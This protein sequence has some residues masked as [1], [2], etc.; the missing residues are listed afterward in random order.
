MTTVLPRPR[1]AAAPRAHLAHPHV[2][3]APAPNSFRAGRPVILADDV[4]GSGCDLIAPA[5]AID[6]RTVAEMV[7]RGAGFLCVTI[8]F[9]TAQRLELPP[10]VWQQS[11]DEVGE[12]MC[13]AVDAVDGT[14]T[15]ISA[16]D[17]GVTLRALA[18]PRSKAASFTRPGHV[19]PVV[20]PDDAPYIDR[21]GLIAKAGRYLAGNHG[22]LAH[23][24]A[25][26]ALVSNRDETQIAGPDEAD[27][28]GLPVLTYSALIALTS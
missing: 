7:R 1:A 17:R 23:S 10:M 16:H 5:A 25:Y 22:S 19:M 28:F 26:T 20:V 8:D 27:D 11:I 6:T 4:W 18:D 15:G 21:A 9:A 12:R 24:V 3:T 13:V 14:T 2:A